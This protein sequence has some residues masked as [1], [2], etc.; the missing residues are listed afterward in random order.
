MPIDDFLARWRNAGGSERFANYQ[1]SS[2]I[3]APCRRRRSDPASDDTRDAYVFER[4]VTFRHGDGRL[5][6]AIDCY[7]RGAFVRRQRKSGPVPPFYDAVC[8][9]PQ[10]FENYAGP[11]SSTGRP[12]FRRRCRQTSSSRSMPSFPAA[13]PPLSRP[14]AASPRRP[15]QADQ[16]RLEDP[17]S[18]TPPP[19]RPRHPEIAPPPRPR[20]PSSEGRHPGRRRLPLRCLFSMFAGR[21]GPA[22]QIDGAF[23]DLLKSF[24]PPGPGPVQRPR[25]VR[26]RRR[27]LE[28]PWTPATSPSPSAPPLQ[29]QTV[30]ASTGGLGN[31]ALTDQIALLLEA[32]NADW[33][34]S[35]TRHLRHPWNVD[36]RR[37]AYAW[38]TRPRLSNARP[39]HRHR[40]L[41][42][43]LDTQT[44]ALLPA[45]EGKLKDA[46]N[47]SGLATTA[48]A[49]SASWTRLR[50]R[51][52]LYV[53]LEHL[54]RLEGEVLIPGHLRRH[55]A[56]PRKAKA[57]P[58]TPPVPGPEINPR[59]P[60]S[61][62]WSCGSATCN[63]TS[64]TRQ[65][66]APSP[67]LKT[68][69]YSMPRRRPR[70]RRRQ[71]RRR[72]GA[73]CR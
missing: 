20:R 60:P 55:P 73:A 50:L 11:A 32:A 9:A 58:W 46:A 51:Q 25:T 40:P 70:P 62:K 35:R 72:R 36:P 7:R 3:S 33:A 39:A 28:K 48:R 16:G 59:P 31:M 22:P 4:R 24:S 34:K 66:P 64:R 21:R 41:P 56:T 69:Q 19:H 38:T 63:G 71:L 18:W 67:I 5:P 52:L 10:R 42:E 49:P 53:T 2:P 47:W 44:A 23:A 65:R 17:L 61:P 6:P 15:R 68:S 57:S 8:C 1:L 37:R 29:R 27:T 14:A 26:P 43:W 12:P 45:H 13:P 54:K 30:Q